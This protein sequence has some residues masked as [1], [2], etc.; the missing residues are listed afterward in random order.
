MTF[1]PGCVTHALH[2][3]PTIELENS[4]IRSEV[5][6]LIMRWGEV[7]LKTKFG[8]LLTGARSTHLFEHLRVAYFHH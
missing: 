5:D 2:A 7:Q 8:N 1:C 3:R 4:R 6:Y